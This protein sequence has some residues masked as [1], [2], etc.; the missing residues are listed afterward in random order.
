MSNPKRLTCS[1]SCRDQIRSQN[2]NLHR[3]V[4]YKSFTFQSNW[5]IAIA[6]FLDKHNIEW[7]QPHKRLKWFDTTQ[8]NNRTY[9]PDFYLPKYNYYLDVKN[10]IK[11]IQDA[12]KIKQLKLLFPLFVGN[13]KET[14]NFVAGMAGL[15][16]A[17]T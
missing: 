14:T 4:Y 8:Q 15:E 9:L 1:N 11:Q 7:E 16:P 2:G 6:E 5:E 10:P 13:I 17:T 3:R 12:D